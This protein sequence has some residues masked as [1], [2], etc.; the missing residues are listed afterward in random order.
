MSNIDESTVVR[1]RD[2]EMDV[3][4][5][6]TRLGVP[7]NHKLEAHRAIIEVPSQDQ[8]E[9]PSTS[10]LFDERRYPGDNGIDV[11]GPYKKYILVFQCKNYTS[12]RIGRRYVAELIGVLN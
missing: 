7:A 9:R 6:L 2:L 1:G 12:D 4:R 8:G 10:I 3:I 11:F 5:V